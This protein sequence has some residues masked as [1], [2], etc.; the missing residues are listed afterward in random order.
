MAKDHL[1]TYSSPGVYVVELDSQSVYFN[2]PSSVPVFIGYTHRAEYSGTS[3][4]NKPVLIQSLAEFKS[5]FGNPNAQKQYDPQFYVEPLTSQISCA[6]PVQIRNR[7]YCICPDPNTIYY[8]YNSLR[9]YFENGGTQAYIVAVGPYGAASGKS[10]PPSEHWVNSN[11][12]RSEL[13]AGLSSLDSTHPA[14]L[15]V[16]PDACLLSQEDYGL[17]MQKALQ[18]SK[19]ADMRFALFDVQD[20]RAP[21]AQNWQRGIDAFRNNTGNEALAFG[22]A[23]YPFLETNSVQSEELDFT[24]LFGGS[25]ELLEELLCPVNDKDIKV[26]KL[27]AELKSDTN[28]RTVQETDKLLRT[29]SDVYVEIHKA[30]VREANLLPPTGGIAGAIVTTDADT[31]V[32]KAPANIGINRVVSLPIKLTNEQQE[33][34]NVDPVSGKSINVIRLFSGLGVLIWGARTLDG[35]SSE[36]RYISVRRTASYIYGSCRSG[37]KSYEFHP[38]NQ[39]TWTAVI[40]STNSFLDGLWQNG[41]LQGASP[42]D[43]YFVRCGLNSTMTQQDIDNG[44][45]IVEV[46][47]SLIYPA[48]FYIVRIV[49][50]MLT[51]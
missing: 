5:R 42:T 22:A 4:W 29:L 24:N 10:V 8:L 6:N 20:G 50:N 13:E 21:D 19:E 30:I 41:G 36:Y 51:N 39:T 32:W 14:T 27:L 38:N 46:G 35:N 3:C 40:S 25:V 47:F 2:I 12:K 45:L 34:L 1:A 43:A 15:I 7:P 23:Y 16:C 9:L 31:G 33:P 44:K 37:L 49:L 11:V 28:K 17:F 48:E 26:S 18:N